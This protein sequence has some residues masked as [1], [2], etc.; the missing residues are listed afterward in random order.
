[1]EQDMY[2]YTGTDAHSLR[3]YMLIRNTEIPRKQAEKVE[4]LMHNNRELFP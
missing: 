2:R 1:L 4:E 3:Q